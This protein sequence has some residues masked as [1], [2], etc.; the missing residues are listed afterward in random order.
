MVGS[1]QHGTMSKDN[2]GW[3]GYL[4]DQVHDKARAI[5]YAS[6]GALDNLLIRSRSG[7]LAWCRLKLFH[8]SNL[9]N[10]LT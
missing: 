9:I 2:E 8:F 5:I 10:L 7:A 1:Q 4:I 3:A 6:T